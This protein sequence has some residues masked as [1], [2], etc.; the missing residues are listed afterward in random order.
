MHI[1]TNIPFL[2][3]PNL[4]RIFEIPES[5]RKHVQIS[6]FVSGSLIAT[7]DWHFNLSNHYTYKF[8][9]N[10]STYIPNATF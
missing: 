6:N 8:E 2:S 10:F 3:T 7:K 1:I 5:Y 4:I 9:V